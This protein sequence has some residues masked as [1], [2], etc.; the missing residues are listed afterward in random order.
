MEENNKVTDN[1]EL[2][3]Y[4]DQYSLGVLEKVLE[5]LEENK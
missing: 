5:I 1:E 2:V 4:L 3:S